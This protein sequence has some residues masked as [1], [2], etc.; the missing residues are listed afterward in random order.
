MSDTHTE[1]LH[2]LFT[3]RPVM[4]AR[5]R[6][7]GVHA[8]TFKTLL[9]G[10]NNK[11]IKLCSTKSSDVRQF[12]ENTL[13][14]R[15][16]QKLSSLGGGPPLS[17]T[18]SDGALRKIKKVLLLVDSLRKVVH[19]VGFLRDRRHQLP[20]VFLLIGQCLCKNLQTYA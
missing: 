8:N 14:Q 17:R 2:S 18:W 5:M 6:Q 9:P 11:K 19:F 4:A 16:I 15:A 20:Q 10:N 1:N 7:H 13:V 12:A 3:E